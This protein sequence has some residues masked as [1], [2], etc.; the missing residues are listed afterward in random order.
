MASCTCASRGLGADPFNRQHCAS[1]LW[2][3]SIRYM[4]RLRRHTKKLLSRRNEAADPSSAPCSKQSYSICSQAASQVN[5]RACT[6]VAEQKRL[7]RKLLALSV[8]RFAV[9]AA[10]MTLRF[11]YRAS[12]LS[13]AESNRGGGFA[14]GF[15][16]GGVVFG[17]LGFLFAPQVSSKPKSAVRCH[18]RA[19]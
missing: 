2:P 13:R 3:C 19:A 5:I 9:T 12:V 16:V 6:A 18:C 14:S 8:L 15:V 1:T 4:W 7:E 17:T 10:R 11:G